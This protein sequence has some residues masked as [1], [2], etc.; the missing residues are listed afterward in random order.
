M[1]SYKIEGKNES[2]DIF[3][4]ASKNLIEIKGNSTLKDTNW[5]YSNLLKWVLAF[6]FGQRHAEVI[7]IHFNLINDSTAKWLLLIFKKLEQLL[8]KNN[9]EINWYFQQTGGRIERIGQRIKEELKL[10]VNLLTT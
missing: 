1:I 3:I 5:F 4:S 8:P 10:N 7:N 2:P 6:N 9:F